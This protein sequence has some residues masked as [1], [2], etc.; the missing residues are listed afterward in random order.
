MTGDRITDIWGARTPLAA[1]AEWAP[2][3][4]VHLDDGIQPA[5]VDRWVPGACVLCSHGCGLDVAVKDG[6]IVGVR[7][8]G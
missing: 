1:G 8:R 2:R 6:R 4:D 3:E 5:D 7:G